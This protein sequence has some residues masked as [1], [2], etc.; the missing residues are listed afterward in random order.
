MKT[1]LR[2]ILVFVIFIIYITLSGETV[3]MKENTIR[4]KDEIYNNGYIYNYFICH[5]IR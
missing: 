3:M 5:L 2:L 4:L 1:N